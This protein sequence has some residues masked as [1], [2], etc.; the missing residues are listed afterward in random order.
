[1]P[2]S[3]DREARAAA[4]SRSTSASPRSLAWPDR[5]SDWPNRVSDGLMARLAVH[6][7]CARGSSER[8]KR[9]HPAAPAKAVESLTEGP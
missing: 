6:P 5:V 4:L 9:S 7:Q 2:A 3:V 8:G 1:M